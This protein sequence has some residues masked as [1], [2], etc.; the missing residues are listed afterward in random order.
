MS[1]N[2][3]AFKPAPPGGFHPA[4]WKAAKGGFGYDIQIE[5]SAPLSQKLPGKMEAEEA[6]WWIAALVRLAYY[7]FLTVP[8][9]SD[10]SFSQIVDSEVDPTLKP[11]ETTPRVVQPPNNAKAMIDEKILE[12]LYEKWAKGAELYKENDDLQAAFRVCDAC[13]IQGRRSSSL[14]AVW[15]ALEQLFSPSHGELRY[16]V[17]SNIAAYLE[18]MGERRLELF[19][20]VLKLYD[21]RS[22]AA[23]TANDTENGPLVKS[24]ILLRNA[25]MKMIESGSVPSQTDFQALLFKGDE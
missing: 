10:L 14:L 24:Y 16:R 18:P 15:G 1:A 3:M 4:P 25:L 21:E 9:I 7:P 23:H 11:F 5:I 12:W 6:V 13:T 22:K 8:V 20:Q 17:S 2:M 19:R